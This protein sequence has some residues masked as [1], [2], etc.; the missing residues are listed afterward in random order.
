MKGHLFTLEP[1]RPIPFNVAL[2]YFLAFPPRRLPALPLQWGFRPAVVH[3]IGKT[4]LFCRRTFLPAF[5]IHHSRRQN[6][7][8]GMAFLRHL[9]RLL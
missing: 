7:E 4:P 5:F 6:G 8:L 9:R 2:I 1:P 3:L